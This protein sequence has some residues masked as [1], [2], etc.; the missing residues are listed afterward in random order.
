MTD[1]AREWKKRQELLAERKPQVR[2]DR[3]MVSEGE[4]GYYDVVIEGVGLLPAIT[5]P[6]IVV[7][8]VTLEQAKYERGG[9]QVTGVLRAPPEDDKVV[10]DLGYVSAEGRLE[11]QSG[12]A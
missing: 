6:H 4:K 5:P 12:K 8:G 10:V 11:I 7:G 9:R 2:V 1:S 3:S